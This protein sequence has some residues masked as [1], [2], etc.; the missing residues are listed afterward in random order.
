MASV[1]LL[2]LSL[3]PE[4]ACGCPHDSCTVDAPKPYDIVHTADPVDKSKEIVLLPPGTQCGVQDDGS[5]M[6]LVPK[7]ESN[8]R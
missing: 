3:L 2:A 1:I 7:Q 6:C 4:T 8:P 5:I